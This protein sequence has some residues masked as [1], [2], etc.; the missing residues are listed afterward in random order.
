MR[1]RTF[2]GPVDV[3]PAGAGP[4][5]ALARTLL[6]EDRVLVEVLTRPNA[7][8]LVQVRFAG[9]TFCRY[10]GRLEAHNDGAR[11]LLAGAE[12][13][14]ER[15]VEKL[16]GRRPEQIHLEAWTLEQMEQLREMYVREVAEHQ[17]VLGNMQRWDQR[18]GAAQARWHAAQ[19]LLRFVN[20]Q[21]K[22]LRRKSSAW[23]AGLSEADR[24]DPVA[25]LTR[26]R[27]LIYRLDR[28]A[29]AAGAAGLTD[30]ERGLIDSV[31]EFIRHNERV[32]AAAGA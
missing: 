8:G 7:L 25:L 2:T 1:V 17:F 13:F 15:S 4:R 31:N 11:E 14:V 26:L 29:K 6:G 18:R 16:E 3:R 19:D 32:P 9:Q 22:K 10:H 21:L 5:Q 27:E 30:E 20:D 24:R 28:Q 23:R 12:R